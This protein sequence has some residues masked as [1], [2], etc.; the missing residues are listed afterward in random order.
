[1]N[2]MNMNIEDHRAVEKAA[3]PTVSPYATF[4]PGPQS[5]HPGGMPLQ[6]G[7]SQLNLLKPIKG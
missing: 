6:E 3:G 2:I 7:A 4:G 5:C 1:M